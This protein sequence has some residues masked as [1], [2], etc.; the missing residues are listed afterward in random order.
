MP[1][2]KK[3]GLESHWTKK[4]IATLNQM[5][6]SHT[7]EEIA[8]AL[9]RSVLS[10]QSKSYRTGL[11]LIS[12]NTNTAFGRLSEIHGQ[13]ILTGSK[14][15]TN[16]DYHSPYDLDWDG[17]RVNVKSSTLQYV[18]TARY[19]YWRF[20]IRKTWINCDLFLML[21]YLS[22]K[23]LPVRAWLIPSDLCQKSVVTIGQHYAKGMYVNYEIEVNNL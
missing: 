17:L 8:Q 14:L 6:K 10:V 16:K 5:R 3:C 15:L 23:E 21:G 2:P 13:K 19:W 1:S 4:E 18:N 11:K 9:G 20:T 22:D 12:N 7:S